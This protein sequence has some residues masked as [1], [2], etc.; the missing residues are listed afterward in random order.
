MESPCSLADECEKATKSALFLSPWGRG[1]VRGF[2]RHRRANA[3]QHTL[4]VLPNLAVPKSQRPDA[5]L[6]EKSGPLNIVLPP[7]WKIMLPAVNLNAQFLLRTIEIQDVWP[8]GLLPP[9][10]LSRKLTVL[11]TVPQSLLRPGHLVA[12]SSSQ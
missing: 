1:E 8:K 7:F 2:L 5:F 6:F 9:K 10:L 12:Q 11:E 4:Q 3:L